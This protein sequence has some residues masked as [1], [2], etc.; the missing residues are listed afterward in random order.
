MHP[1]ANIIF[2][3]TAD[4]LRHLLVVIAIVVVVVTKF[5]VIAVVAP[6]ALTMNVVVMVTDSVA[7]VA[8][9]VRVGF[10]GQEWCWCAGVYEELENV[11]IVMTR[12]CHTHLVTEEE[13]AAHRCG[14]WHK[15]ARRHQL[16]V[17]RQ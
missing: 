10:R 3:A 6:M 16:L 12:S 15:F 5:V 2:G 11:R 4:A 1:D 13:D 17:R 14:P 9:I 8:V 7:M